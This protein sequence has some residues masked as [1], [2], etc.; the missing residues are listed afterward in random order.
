MFS[1]WVFI[2]K[3]IFTGSKGEMFAM[4]DWGRIAEGGHQD[5]GQIKIEQKMNQEGVANRA[6]SLID[7]PLVGTNVAASRKSGQVT[8]NRPKEHTS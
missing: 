5:D 7:Q 1:I 8:L 6:E 3:H 4:Y 2:L